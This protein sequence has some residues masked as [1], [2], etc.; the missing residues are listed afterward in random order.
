[1]NESDTLLT[2]RA[3]DAILA[4]ILDGALQ[5][6]DRLVVT[7]LADELGMSRTPVRDALKRLAVTRVVQSNDS[8]GFRVSTLTL[9]DVRNLVEL[10]R[11]LESH[12]AHEI[13]HRSA[14][15]RA[16]V[17]MAL[18]LAGSAA[19]HH[20]HIALGQH[21]ENTY[22]R[23]VI[24]ILNERLAPVRA[25]IAGPCDQGDDHA[26]IVDAVRAGDGATARVAVADHLDALRDAIY[27]EVTI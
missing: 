20:F 2:Q 7:S 9:R 12:V 15:D 3:R 5:A 27:G 4:S 6:G 13:T 21:A 1:M 8:S 23:E 22:L 24:E 19:G 17:A 18:E 14:G 26:A 11:L 16:A 10:L 25:R